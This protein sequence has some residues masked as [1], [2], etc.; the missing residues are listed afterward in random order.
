MPVWISLWQNA[1]ILFQQKIKNN[2]KHTIFN[3]AFRAEKYLFLCK[4]VLYRSLLQ[5]SFSAKHTDE[6]IYQSEVLG[7]QTVV[8]G[9]YAISH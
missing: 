2:C 3:E 8:E 6:F 7:E 4:I 1:I 9:L 5:H